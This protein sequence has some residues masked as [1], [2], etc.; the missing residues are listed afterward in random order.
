MAVPTTLVRWAPVALSVLR[1]V[2]GLLF[3][4]HGTQKLF[5]FPPGEQGAPE[6][7]TLPWFAGVIELVGGLM[8]AIVLGAITIWLWKSAMKRPSARP[9]TDAPPI[10]EPRGKNE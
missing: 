7:M 9:Q 3:L 6:M 2:A 5:G 1:I 10:P 8:M 4:E